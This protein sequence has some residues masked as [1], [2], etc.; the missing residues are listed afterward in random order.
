MP[1]TA[2]LVALYSE[3]REGLRDRHHLYDVDVDVRGP[4][5]YPV[6]AVCYVFRRQSLRSLV[7][8]SSAFLVA[9]EAHFGKFGSTY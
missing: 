5:G 4:G 1:I 6:N 9:F 2:L 3:R 7:N 8:G